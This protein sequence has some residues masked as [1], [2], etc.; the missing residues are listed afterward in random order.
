MS[1][2]KFDKAI[3][4]QGTDYD[5]RR[6]L[7]TDDIIKIQRAY[8]QGHSATELASRYN[9]TIPTIMYHVD[10]Q[11]KKQVNSRRSKFAY[12]PFDSTEQLKSRVKHKKAILAGAI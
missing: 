12:A 9:V 6:K 3:R 5:R 4:I 7:T 8:A 2:A 1:D 11:H 10:P